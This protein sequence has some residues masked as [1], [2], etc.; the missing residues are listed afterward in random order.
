M[1]RGH[2]GPFTWETAPFSQNNLTI[3]TN[4][5]RASANQGDDLRFTTVVDKHERI[6]DRA[7]VVPWLERKHL[8]R[9]N[10]EQSQIGNRTFW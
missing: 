3:R 4:E 6:H 7:A 1:V 8:E 10:G 2:F 9:R 5:R